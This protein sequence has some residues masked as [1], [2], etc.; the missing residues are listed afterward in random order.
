MQ[1][2]SFPPVLVAHICEPKISDLR[3]YEE[4]NNGHY[5]LI[6]DYRSLGKRLSNVIYLTGSN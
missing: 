6:N 4:G 5:Y 2:P 1:E 3:E